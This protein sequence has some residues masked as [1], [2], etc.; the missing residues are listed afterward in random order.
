MLTWHRSVGQIWGR[1]VWG[2]RE[3]KNCGSGS[4][5]FCFPSGISYSVSLGTRAIED[6]PTSREQLKSATS[7]QNLNRNCGENCRGRDEIH[8]FPQAA[9]AAPEGESVLIHG[10][11]MFSMCFVLSPCTGLG[12]KRTGTI[13]SPSHSPWKVDAGGA[14]A[15]HQAE[16]IIWVSIKWK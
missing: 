9:P 4:R 2:N 1:S 7:V 14:A 16:D 12:G 15:I 13:S 11:M 8:A 5:W 10:A 6:A 3:G